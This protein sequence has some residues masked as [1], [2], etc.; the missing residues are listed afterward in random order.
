MKVSSLFGRIF[1]FG[2]VGASGVVV[3]M[4]FLALFKSTL[5]LPLWI[6]SFLA[7]EISI[8]TNFALND[9]W[10]WKDQRSR[11]FVGRIWRY[12]LS[13]GITAYGIN[14]P[15]VLALTKYLGLQY[16]VSN[17]IGIVIASCANFAINHF[18]TYSK[19]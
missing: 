6:A 5:D 14:Y 16:L 15:L 12:H 10:T 4:G 8:L 17:L 18:W 19:D 1:K 13:V 9:I 11:A 2:V 3:N 7:I